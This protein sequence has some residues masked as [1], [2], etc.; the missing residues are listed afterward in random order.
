[1]QRCCYLQQAPLNAQ[2]S[3]WEGQLGGM[4]FSG[5]PEEILHYCNHCEVVNVILMMPSLVVSQG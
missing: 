1:M 2:L 3:P 5:A 4:L